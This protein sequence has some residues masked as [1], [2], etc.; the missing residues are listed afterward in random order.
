MKVLEQVGHQG[1]TMW[2]TIN[3]IPKEAKRVEKMFIA[4][5]EQSGSVHA[6]CGKYDLYSLEDGFC[7]DVLDDCR[8]NHTFKQN[9]NENSL[10]KNIELPMKDHRSSVLP[11][12]K[13]F[14][15]IQQRYDP[16]KKLWKKVTD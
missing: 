13:Y 1:D 2:F 12:G 3:E 7:V 11:K 4:Q 10:N 16:L 8:I 9:I 6:L 5:S 14:V 15:G